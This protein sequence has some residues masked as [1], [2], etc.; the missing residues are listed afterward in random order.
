MTKDVGSFN[1]F[2]IG[3]NV[4]GGNSDTDDNTDIRKTKDNEIPKSDS[5]DNDKVSTSSGWDI[6]SA[7]SVKTEDFDVIDNSF[8]GAGS[9]NKILEWHKRNG[10]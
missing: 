2:H 7:E 1:V 10:N 5:R 4:Y 9:I 3:N 6:A 8:K